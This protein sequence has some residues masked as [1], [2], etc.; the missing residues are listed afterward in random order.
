MV[1]RISE[2]GIW[3]SGIFLWNPESLA[4]EFNDLNPKSITWNTGIPSVD[5]RIQ[6]FLALCFCLISSIQQSFVASGNYNV[7]GSNA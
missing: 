1:I 5:S 3:N 6:V 4:L 7:Q 2:S